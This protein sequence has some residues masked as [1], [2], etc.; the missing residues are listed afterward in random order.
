MIKTGDKIQVRF[1]RAGLHRRLLKL[2]WA[3]LDIETHSD[4]GDLGKE[5]LD[6]ML[7]ASKYEFAA[8]IQ[9]S[10]KIYKFYH[11]L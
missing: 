1:H 10:S 6:G 7:F 8:L 9:P 11:N 2:L 5:V 4:P 3:V